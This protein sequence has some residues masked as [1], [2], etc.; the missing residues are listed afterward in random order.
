MAWE[1]I[2]CF[3][4]HKV[5]LLKVSPF[6]I[7]KWCICPLTKHRDYFSCPFGFL[8]SS[9]ELQAKS[10]V[11]RTDSFKSGTAPLRLIVRIYSHP[12]SPRLDPRNAVAVPSVPTSVP[13]R[14]ESRTHC[15]TPMPYFSRILS[16]DSQYISAYKMGKAPEIEME[17]RVERLLLWRLRAPM[18]ARPS[19]CVPPSV[20]TFSRSPSCSLFL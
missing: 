12:R 15:P 9:E 18:L 1:A 11:L 3:H 14:Q 2:K 7:S 13:H 6:W 17:Q 16:R 8:S 10:S 5:K 19:D 4:S 20:P